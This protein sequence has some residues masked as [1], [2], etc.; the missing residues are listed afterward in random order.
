MSSQDKNIKI[1]RTATITSADL[2]RYEGTVK[3]IRNAWDNLPEDVEI[4][5]REMFVEIA[6]RVLTLQRTLREK[7]KDESNIN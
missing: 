2:D 5:E 4:E 7:D 1:N 3:L 6:S